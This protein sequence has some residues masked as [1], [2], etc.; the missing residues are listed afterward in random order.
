[1]EINFP[2][3]ICI[4]PVRKEVSFLIRCLA[5]SEIFF[6]P[7]CCYLKEQTPFLSSSVTWGVI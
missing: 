2:S 3:Q 1:M 7:I 4:F 5:V 6:F